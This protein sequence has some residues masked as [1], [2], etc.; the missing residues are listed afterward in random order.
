MDH[1]VLEPRPAAVDSRSEPGHQQPLCFEAMLIRGV[2]PDTHSNEFE[3]VNDLHISIAVGSQ[4]FQYKFAPF[5]GNPM[6]SS[7]AFWQNEQASS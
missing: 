7:H 1:L 3:R 2:V 5:V 6:S 4:T